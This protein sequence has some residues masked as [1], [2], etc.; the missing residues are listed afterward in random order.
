MHFLN[1]IDKNKSIGKVNICLQKSKTN[2]NVFVIRMEI[3]KNQEKLDVKYNTDINFINEIVEMQTMIR[4]IPILRQKRELIVLF[5]I[6][7]RTII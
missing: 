3:E 1:V 2:D 5:F 4:N 7:M 6:I